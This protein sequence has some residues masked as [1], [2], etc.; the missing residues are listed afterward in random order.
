MLDLILVGLDVNLENQSVAVFNL[1]SGSFRCD[2]LLDDLVGVQ[3]V[4]VW[5]RLSVLWRSCQ[6]QS[7]WKSEG[8]GSSDLDSLG[9]VSTLKSGFLSRL[10]LSGSCIDRENEG[11]KIYVSICSVWLKKF[12]TLSLC[13]QMIGWVRGH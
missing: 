11:G 12:S 2:W 6:L 3:S 7:L 8:S 5:N 4:V 9:R 13:N 1:L 10:S